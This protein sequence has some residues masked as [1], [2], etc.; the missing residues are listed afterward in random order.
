MKVFYYLYRGEHL[1]VFFIICIFSISNW[2]SQNGLLAGLERPTCRS[3]GIRLINKHNVRYVY[4]LYVSD[5]QDCFSLVFILAGKLV[6]ASPVYASDFRDKPIKSNI[7]FVTYA[8]NSRE[9]HF[10][11][12]VA[13]VTFLS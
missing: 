4:A 2:R 13:F 5:K 12:N 9:K 3:Q 6:S 11:R 7:F 1:K 10:V 8:S